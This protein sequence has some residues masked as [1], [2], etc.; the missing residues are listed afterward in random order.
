MCSLTYVF[1]KLSGFALTGQQIRTVMG[2]SGGN[3]IIKFKYKIR[4]NNLLRDICN[5]EVLKCFTLINTDRA[6]EWK[7][8]GRFYVHDD[9]SE[10]FLNVFIRDLNVKDSGE[11][12]IIV[13]VSEDYSFFS[14][15]YLDIKKGEPFEFTHALLYMVELMNLWFN[16]N[17]I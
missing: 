12:K 15:F 6:A 5:T 13:T 16:V 10:G 9:R 3:I 7:H 8:V 17:L 11:Y 2:Y 14:E 1:D 4:Q